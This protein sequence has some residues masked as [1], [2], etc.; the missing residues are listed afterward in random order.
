VK[1]GQGPVF[2]GKQ[3]VPM[4]A[5]QGFGAVGAKQGQGSGIGVADAILAQ[6]KNGVRADLQQAK[7]LGGFLRPCCFGGLAPG[8]H[9]GRVAGHCTQ[10][11]RPSRRRT[12][13]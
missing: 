10:C 8:A 1:L 6:H 11:L 5:V 13:A 2:G 12:V 7:G 3:P 9:V 4:H